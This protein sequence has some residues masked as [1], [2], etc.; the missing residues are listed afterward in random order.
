MWPTSDVVTTAMDAGSDTPPRAEIKSW[1]DKFNEMRNHVSV[2]MQGLLDDPDAATARAT[3][4]V[5]PFMRNCHQG[6]TLSTAGSSTTMTIGAGQCADSGNAVLI[7]LAASINKTTASWAVGSGN[8]GLDTG[9]I[10]NSTW[11]FFHVI[12]RPDTGVVDVLIS[13]SATA[14]TMPTN[15]TQRRLLMAWRTNGSGQWEDWYQAGDEVFY[16]TIVLTN[17][18]NN[19]AN[20]SRAAYAMTT[21]PI[22]CGASV[23]VSFNTTSVGA[24]NEKSLYISSASD[25]D[26]AVTADNRNFWSEFKLTGGALAVD[27]KR[28]TVRTNSAAEIFA[29]TSASGSLTR[30]L[31]TGFNFA[32]PKGR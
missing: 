4:G 6:F 12:R 1:A 2:F 27:I 18:V 11:Y 7:D 29:R 16:K 9:T 24:D 30:L 26:V 25:A 3:L 31:T 28:M 10:A 14:P 8:G 32:E 13:M 15:Y 23:Q 17:T 19:I 21:P 20:A 22:V 5:I